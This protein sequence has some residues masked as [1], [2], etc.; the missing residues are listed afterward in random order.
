VSPFDIENI[1]VAEGDLSGWDATTMALV[2]EVVTACVDA[3]REA[4]ARVAD[5]YAEAVKTYPWVKT[6]TDIAE[7]IRN[8]AK[9]AE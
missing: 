6:A 3:E 4:C 2:F 7:Q 9:S 1:V 8:R 5:D